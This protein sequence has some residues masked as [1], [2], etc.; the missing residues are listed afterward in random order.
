MN[1][2]P[3]KE[4]MDL[5]AKSVAGW[6]K[7]FIFL[8]GVYL[9]LH[10][11][12]TPGGGFAGGVV[13]ACAFILLTLTEGQ[14]VGLEILGKSFAAKLASFAALIFLA[15]AVAAACCPGVFLNELPA[16][17]RSGVM[18]FFRVNVMFVYD[19]SLALV[20]S[21]LI[22]VVFSVTA[23]VHVAINGG[24]RRMMRKRRG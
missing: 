23:A 13:M 15:A 6:L 5:V 17:G 9:V 10:G 12:E 16:G 1:E 18:S 7:G 20:V 3:K 8:F 21:M 14:R 22:Y 24:K 11:H 4:G 19:F 2:T